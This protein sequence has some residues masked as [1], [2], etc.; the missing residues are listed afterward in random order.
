MREPNWRA[1]LLTAIGSM[2]VL[3]GIAFVVAAPAR[4]QADG[5]CIQLLIDGVVVFSSEACE[6]DAA[7]SPTSE[8]PAAAEVIPAA[9]AALPAP[10]SAP[11]TATALPPTATAIPA[12]P[13]RPRA[14][15]TAA[16]VV[17]DDALYWQDWSWGSGVNAV[18]TDV[19]HDGDVS[20]AVTPR[21]AW[22]GLYLHAPG[23]Q[24]LAASGYQ[25]VRFW[26]HGG[27]GSGELI[28]ALVDG[29]DNMLNEQRVTLTRQPDQWV[30]V[31]LSLAE[32]GNP[33]T[34]NGLIIMADSV[35]PVYHVDQVEFLGSAPA[36]PDTSAG[37][38]SVYPAERPS[39]ALG[40]TW[41]GETFFALG[42]N[43]AWYD[44][45]YDVG[46]GDRGFAA[47]AL[48]P[49]GSIN[50]SSPLVQGIVD[51]V[52]NH[53]A[54]VISWWLFPHGEGQS[55]P[56]GIATDNRG[57]PA[58]LAPGVFDDVDAMVL[59]AE[60]Y[61]FYWSFVLFNQPE[62]WTDSWVTTYRGELVNAV[63][64][65][66][67]RY[68]NEPRIMSY[69][70]IAEAEFS[71]WNGHEKKED[72][73]DIGV[74]LV[75][76]VQANTNQLVT[77]Q[78]A[79]AD[80]FSDWLGIADLDYLSASWYDYMNTGTYCM[81]CNDAAFYSSD[82]PVLVYE[83]Y[84]GP[85]AS[86]TAPDRTTYGPVGRWEALYNKGYAGAYAWMI[87]TG[88]AQDGMTIDWTGLDDFAGRHQD[89]GP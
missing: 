49:D 13:T 38:G 56:A 71:Y 44:Y 45:G 72:I 61:D 14:S 82:L 54:R 89:V 25:T 51:A 50:T 22:S 84:T 31:E 83:V 43:G 78:S 2:F 58:G 53:D 73:L 64:P 4:A 81:I 76:A 52:Q 5:S 27:S 75:E 66:L 63:T 59:L 74:R 20:I 67:Q 21:N 3:A 86:Y 19:V 23:G 36:A 37:S 68:A 55:P 69:N 57:R 40:L 79:F 24:G 7:P 15:E 87:F 8:P 30:Q 17:Y 70:V 47:R 33:G 16:A 41:Q 26:L 34:I 11:P 39:T 62:M 9:T 10:T 42:A 32:L 28:V 85:S 60:T 1:G 65:L 29:G 46:G 48:S 35:Q 6:T 77:I 88:R 12:E 18:S 80:G